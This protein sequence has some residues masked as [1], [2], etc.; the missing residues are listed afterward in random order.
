MLLLNGYTVVKLNVTTSSDIFIHCRATHLSQ[1]PTFR[2]YQ[3]LR[4][5]TRKI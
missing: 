1:W 2:C 5:L 4:F 3:S